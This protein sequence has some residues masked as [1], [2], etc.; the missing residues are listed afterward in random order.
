VPTPD[1]TENH[2]VLAVPEGSEWWV[3]NNWDN[4]IEPASYLAKWWDWDFYWP[5]FEQYRHL[6]RSGNG[7]RYDAAARPRG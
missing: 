7:S 4:R 3:L 6:V 2:V 5:P 1:G